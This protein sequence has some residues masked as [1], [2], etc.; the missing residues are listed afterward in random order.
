MPSKPCLRC[1]DLIEGGSRC[2]KCKPRR[3]S[4]AKRGSGGRAA[5]FRRHTLAITGGVCAV[6]GSEDQV[7]AHH[8]GE[9]DAD[10]GVPL[11]DRCHGKVTAA[12]NRAR[13]A[14][15]SH[16]LARKQDEK[17]VWISQRKALERIEA[18]QPQREALRSIRAKFAI[19]RRS[20][21]R[22]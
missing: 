9:T 4:K 2:S 18:T 7:E 22:A 3:F 5:T 11:C 17:P 8:L 21:E 6:C 1:G 10:G 12:V 13:V 15:A 14:S 16:R 20:R 19:T